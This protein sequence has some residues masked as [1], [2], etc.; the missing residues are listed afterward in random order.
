M[1]PRV[2]RPWEVVEA[3]RVLGDSIDWARVRV[4]EGARWPLGLA[5][6]A[7][8]LQGSTP[9]AHN[10]VTLGHRIF[11][12]RNLQTHLSEGSTLR[13]GDFAWLVHE[14]V[15]VWQ[16]ERLGVLAMWRF[17]RL[18]L[19]R[20]VNPYEYG[21]ADGLAKNATPRSLEDFTLEQQGEIAQ[22]YYARLDAG[23]DTRAWE[24]V[25]AQLR[26]V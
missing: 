3:K 18:H 21:G 15:H 7:A 19:R 16:Y 5:R 13:R 2:L 10:A 24:P 26:R 14:L 4:V 23:E 11:F 17:A 12:S 25:I 6:L 9:P 22:D 1:S 8:R 20:N